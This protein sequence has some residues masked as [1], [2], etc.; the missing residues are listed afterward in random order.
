MQFLGLSSACKQIFRS[1]K[2]ELLENPCQGEDVRKLHF[3]VYT[4]TGNQ[5]FFFFG[6]SL[7]FDVIFSVRHFFVPLYL[8]DQ[9]QI[10]G[11]D[12]T[13]IVLLAF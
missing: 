7:S 8:L 13:E 1:L 2:T 10:S 5:G 9:L 4:Y 11:S 6:L 3:T 12:R